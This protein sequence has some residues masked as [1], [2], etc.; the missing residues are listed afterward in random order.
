[1]SDQLFAKIDHQKKVVLIYGPGTFM[2]KDRIKAFGPARWR[3]DLK[4]WEVR[5]E[6][7]SESA[8]KSHFPE[9]VFEQDSSVIVSPVEP[10]LIQIVTEQITALSRDGETSVPIEDV[11]GKIK[12]PPGVSVSKLLNEIRF[13]INNYF[14]STRFVYGVLTKV[15]RSQ[16]RVFLELADDQSD[17]QQ[18]SLVIWGNEEG[19]CEKLNKAGFVL[20]AGLQVMFEVAVQLS[21][22]KAFISF[23]VQKIVHEYTIAKLAAKREVTNEQLK[24]E[25]IFELNKKIS[26]PA[27]PRRIGLLTSS[28]GTVINDFRAS[29]D[30]SKFGFQLF[31]YPVNVQGDRAVKDILKGL[32][33]LEKSDVDL[34]L[35][36][37]GGGSPA[38][39]AVF[40][41]YELAKAVCLC[42]KPI[43]SA[44]GH[45]ED[46]CSVQDISCKA[47]GVP[48]EIGHYLAEIIINFRREVLQEARSIANQ[49]QV[50]VNNSQ[51]KLKTLS[52][53]ISYAVSES[54][55]K[56]AVEMRRLCQFAKSYAERIYQTRFQEL[57]LFSKQIKSNADKDFNSNKLLLLQ[58]G[59]KFAPSV[60]LFLQRLVTRMKSTVTLSGNLNYLIKEKESVIQLKEELFKNIAPETQLQ[61]GFALVKKESGEYATRGGQLVSGEAVVLEFSDLTKSAQIK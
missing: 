16:G 43:F 31:W 29:L 39:L 4:Q 30:T 32:K 36:F 57:S 9:I 19:I 52:A 60:Q 54:L 1:M 20:E 15:T 14:S 27:L 41:E 17:T 21:S 53:M 6:E 58:S 23:N 37:R 51:E 18:I 26:V 45:E 61:R 40:S 25:G 2:A 38:D 7:L 48:K 24:K 11:D 44:I 13:L 8:I 59:R 47:F 34:I 28:A 22:K 12:T 56:Q 5:V 35:I 49:T 55:G 10:E 33:I 3:G 42:K 46:Q 50:L